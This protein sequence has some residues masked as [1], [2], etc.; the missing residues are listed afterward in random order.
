MFFAFVGLVIA[1]SSVGMLYG[2]V[3]GWLAF[4]VGIMVLATI[5]GIL[6]RIDD[7]RIQRLVDRED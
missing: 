7:H 2:E 3:I 4:G 1:A 6:D 5:N